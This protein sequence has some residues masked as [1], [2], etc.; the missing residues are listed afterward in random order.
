[1]QQPVVGSSSVALLA[2]LIAIDLIFV[3]LHLLHLYSRHYTNIG[4]LAPM[5]SIEQDRGYGELW[6]YVK[7]LA[8]V[9]LLLGL[10]LRRAS[11]SYLSWAFLFLSFLLDDAL[12][13]HERLGEGAAAYLGY[14]PGLNLRAN[15]LGELTVVALATLVFGT[16]LAF[17][18]WR[19]DVAFRRVS[20]RL[21][22]LVGVLVV[23]GIGMDA[24]HIMVKNRVLG[25]ALG[26]VEEGGEMVAVSLILWYTH[27]LFR[28]SPPAARTQPAPAWRA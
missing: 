15:D 25:T 3:T 24:I 4:F 14:G 21:A 2:I 27:R 18:W 22:L 5:F 6:Q 13:L 8:I 20:K 10:S 28:A 7:T 23:F 9:L 1:M 19:G 11:R 12:E 16:L 17:T 26:F